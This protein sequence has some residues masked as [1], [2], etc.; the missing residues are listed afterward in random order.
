MDDDRTGGESGFW[1]EERLQAGRAAADEL[2]S[3][4]NAGGALTPLERVPLRLPPGE[5]P[6]ASFE[7]EFARYYGTAPGSRRGRQI[8][9]LTP[10]GLAS[11][12]L[13][14]GR[15][16]SLATVSGRP[17]WREEQLTQGIL[18]GHRLLIGL[19]RGWHPFPFEN[20]TEF[21]PNA[22]D[23]GLVLCFGPSPPIRL[24]GPMIPWVALAMTRLLQP[25]G[26]MPEVPGLAP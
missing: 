16:R 26:P 7:L 5:R 2:V 8:V 9:L 24:R 13:R 4:L 20:I 15:A 22:A 10:G 14:R 17:R 1:D 18:T 12:A 3:H 19:S 6:Y 11:Y 23:F 25:G 21:V